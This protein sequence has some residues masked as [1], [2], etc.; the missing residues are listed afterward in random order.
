M[1][2][3]HFTESQ[4]VSILK[5]A[6]NGLPVKDVVRN[7]GISVPTYYTWKSRYD[8]M[9]VAGLVRVRALETEN[10]QAQA[11]LCRAGFGERG[12]SRI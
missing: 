7:H 11:D 2:K 4:I 6:D 8:G 12:E 9:D 1:R 3:S 5:E 10:S